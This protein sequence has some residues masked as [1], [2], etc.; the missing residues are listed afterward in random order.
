MAPN[1]S[2]LVTGVSTAEHLDDFA[3]TELGISAD[4]PKVILPRCCFVTVGSS[5][6][7]FRALLEEVISEHFL[8][9]MKQTG[10]QDMA[11]QCG[12]DLEWFEEQ[13][14][15]RRTFG[16]KIHCFDF[17]DEIYRYY[18][19]CRG[20]YRARLAGCVIAHCGKQA[21]SIHELMDMEE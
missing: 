4:A 2:V 5:K 8:K 7:G 1:P 21:C 19:C 14:K 17:T 12:P 16:I 13:L 3:R 15:G 11:V 10:Y 6:A 9:F 20:E 18:L